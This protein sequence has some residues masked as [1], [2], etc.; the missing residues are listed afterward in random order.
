M[1]GVRWIGPPEIECCT[2]Q[3]GALYCEV[4]RRVFDI[5]RYPRLSRSKG[6]SFRCSS[7]ARSSPKSR[8]EARTST[9]LSWEICA[10]ASWRHTSSGFSVSS[11]LV[12]LSQ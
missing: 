5:F 11:L 3:S 12:N 9:G 6:T 10:S 2:F 8:P 1:L 7:S 4:N